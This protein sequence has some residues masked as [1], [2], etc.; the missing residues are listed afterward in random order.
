MAFVLVQHLAP[1]HESI[2]AE[3]IRRST[4]ME[5][6]EV[7]DGMVVSPNCAYIIPP[8]KD[9]AFINGALQLLKPAAPLGQ[10]LPIDFFFRSLAL[11]QHQHAIGIVLS[12]TGSDVTAGIRAIKAEGG[13]ALV[14]KLESAEYDGM[15]RSV[16]ATGLADFILPPA[17]MPKQLISYVSHA[18]GTLARVADTKPQT[19]TFDKLF[20]LLRNHTGHDFSQYKPGT[21]HRRIERRMAVN[22]INDI[23]GYL[24]YLMQ[25]QDEV[26][27]LYRDLLIGVTSF[28][29][30]P[31]AFSYL[32]G[33]LLPELLA[34]RS[35]SQGV[36][37]WSAGC[38]TGEEAYSLAILLAEWQDRMKQRLKVQIFATDLDA[39]AIATARSGLFPSSISQDVSEKRLS[40]YFRAEAEGAFYRIRKDIRDML[41]FSEHD[42]IKDPPFSKLDL[43][44]CRNLM[45]Y[46]NS[47]L[48]NKL[49]PLFHYALRPQGILM[50]GTSE[51]I[52][53]FGDLYLTL[54]R[55]LKLYQ[56]KEDYNTLRQG[57]VSPFLLPALERRGS[58]IQS[59]RKDVAPAIAPLRDITERALLQH[60]AAVGILVNERGDILYLHGRS[61]LYL[62]PTEGEISTANILKMARS[63]L[64]E[65]LAVAF[66]RSVAAKR[67]V[68]FPDLSVKTNGSY[69]RCNLTIRS[70]TLNPDSDTESTLYLVIIESVKT[71]TNKKDAV[72]DPVT[73]VVP[74]P[75][76]DTTIT[77]LQQEL[78]I[79][80]A[81]LRTT[82]EEVEISNEELKSTNEEMQSINEELHSTNEELETSKEELQSVNEELATVNSELQGKVLDLTRANN[83]M[84]NLL[85]GTGIGTVFVDRKLQIIRFTPSVTKIINLILSDMGRP[86]GHI[87][88]NLVDYDSLVADTQEVLD[89]LVPKEIEV[90]TRNGNW[91]AMNIQ[92][93]RTLEN[94]IE[95]A[96][97]TFF[98]ITEVMKARTAIQKA[99]A[100]KRLAKVIQD[101]KDA[102]I[103]QDLNGCILAWNPSAEKIYGWTE[104][105]ALEMHDQDRIPQALHEASKSMLHQLSRFESIETF[106]TQRLTKAGRIVDVSMT[107]TALLNELGH[108][109][110]VSTMERCADPIEKQKPRPHVN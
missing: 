71:A 56:R 4:S 43:L 32:E 48:Q 30:D 18:Y 25:S 9:M 88:S 37:I 94:A 39:Q 102:I 28:F 78:E 96:V 85:S 66:H 6:S 59:H 91:Y 34:N 23:D 2:L 7:K 87:V 97:I 80:E 15:P 5:V 79:K 44:C 99:N 84:N 55:K 81:Y 65:K 61:G 53:Q 19:D 82:I 10:R 86:I 69:T 22:Q 11:D 54:D 95:G 27:V 41:I 33:E 12:G 47:E 38:S 93:Y 57:K 14:Q 89:S 36:R 26:D 104:A 58:N 16:I 49:I 72:T 29:R 75:D 40:R 52:G 35:S 8:N 110:A 42:I 67:T 31:K 46:L 17:E 45:I 64:Q 103:V 63:G 77:M 73:S 98:E 105:E 108:V 68:H 106:Q 62:E 50:L 74:D 100:F 83:D 107:A 76:K 109:Y 70:V 20:Y 1:D 92:P 24:K 21:I 90:R 3:L 51:S 60:L 13:I 101:S